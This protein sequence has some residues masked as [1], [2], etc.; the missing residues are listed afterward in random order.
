MRKRLGRVII[1]VVVSSACT[2]TDT[3]TDTD[4]DT[5]GDTDADED[6]NT[7]ENSKNKHQKDVPSGIQRHRQVVCQQLSDKISIAVCL[8]NSGDR[9][10]KK[11]VCVVVTS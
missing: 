7:D 3:D 5:D 10:K 2:Y 1:T 9:P 6:T 4:G 11:M 8:E